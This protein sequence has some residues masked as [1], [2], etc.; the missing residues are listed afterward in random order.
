[1]AQQATQTRPES[2]NSMSVLPQHGVPMLVVDDNAAKLK[3][4]V[5]LLED[6]QMD[7]KI[8]TASSGAEALA[9]VLRADYAL[10]LLDVNM[11]G[12]SGFETA[13]AIRTRRRSRS[14]PLIFV[15][16]DTAADA[17]LYD[18][19]A[20][21]AV[22]FVTAPIVPELLQAKVRVFASM[23]QMRAD[24]MR[25][26]TSLNRELVVKEKQERALK[27]ANEEL[28]QSRADL[29]E[30]TRQ[31]TV[32]EMSASVGRELTELIATANTPIIGVAP[33]GLVNEW[34]HAAERHLGVDRDEAL[35]ERFIER[36]VPASERRRAVAALGSLLE[37]TPIESFTINLLSR[38]GTEVEMLFSV[39]TR[40]N[41]NGE[42]TGVLGIGQNITELRDMQAQLIQ[43]SKLASLGEMSAGVAHELN[44]PLNVIRMASVNILRKMD[45]GHELDAAYLRDKLQRIERQTV[46]AAVIIDHM[47]MFGRI[48]TRLDEVIDINDVVQSSL[49]MVRQQLRLELVELDTELESNLPPTLG[50]VI[51]LEQVLINLVN[52]ARDAY[53]ERPDDAQESRRIRI[54]SCRVDDRVEIRVADRAGGIPEALLDR[55]FE[56]FF[57]TKEVGQGTGLGLSVSYG[58]IREMQGELRARNVDGG[59]EMTISLP[60]ATQSPE[61]PAEDPS[62]ETPSGQGPDG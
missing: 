14:T 37:G 3:S 7:L 40:R 56:P 46:R 32:H 49:E 43:A 1:M 4:L 21:G 41:S 26:N 62:A 13:R 45:A 12:M 23:W 57:T 61:A 50:S 10:I 44:Q 54:S 35:G 58:I 33:D 18:G 6:V 34:N 22:D 20:L 36:Y 24:L 51:Q 38:N 42:V 5:A 19:Y 16:S 47:R 60:V 9:Q 39:T 31:A 29:V 28:E 8:D 59:A 2:V 53:R 30:V 27:K 15:T 25:V 48:A 11:P 55:I 17:A 52:N